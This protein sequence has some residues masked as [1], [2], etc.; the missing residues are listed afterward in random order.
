MR[1]FAIV[2][3]LAF[4]TLGAFV[5]GQQPASPP[6]RPAVRAGD[7][8][9][10]SGALPT[11]PDG[12][13]VP[14]DIRAQ[15]RQALENLKAVLKAN[16][17]RLERVASVSVY[18]KR[19]ADFAPMN[20]VY[21]TY[22]PS[23]PPARTTVIANLVVPDALVEISM[24][25]LVDAA[26]RTVVHPAGWVKP[27]SPYSYAIRSGDVLFLS[28]LVPRNGADNSPIK[29]D[30]TAQANAVLKNAGEILKAANLN[31]AEVVSARVFL[32]DAGAFE[33]LNGVWRT[34][35]PKDPPARATVRAGLTSPDYLVE[36]ALTAAA[37]KDRQVVTTPNADLT[38]GKPNPNLS[39]AVRVGNRLFLS[40]MLGSI[41]ANAG[42]VRA[43]TRETL[44]RISRTLQAAGFEWR[45]V[46]DSTVYLTDAGR[47][48][49][50]NEAYRGA[51]GKDFPAR[52]TIE[53]ALMSRAAL[54]EIMA[55]AYK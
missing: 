4:L 48:S 3:L 53:A 52:A 49:E 29:G 9:Y 10:L 5:R 24:I 31:Y 22:W 45:H 42:D 26:E 47:A 35:F 33:A 32:T 1:R 30:I 6:F 51:L 44:A 20:E 21:A 28:G 12:K 37:G 41:D 46:V 19:A 23:D 39:S 25:A 17:A 36:I 55:N 27:P 18:L 43:Q 16:G 14:G 8:V 2:A 34:H 13:V 50:M 40:G 54:V 11:G 15:T 7:L 38:P